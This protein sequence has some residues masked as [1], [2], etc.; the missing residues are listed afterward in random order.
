VTAVLWS[1]GSIIKEK[2]TI[3]GPAGS[4]GMASVYKA[5]HIP[6]HELRALKV[7]NAEMSADEG[8]HPTLYTGG[9]PSQKA[10][11]P[12]CRACGR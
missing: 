4:G 9:S 3:I 2:Y 12:E 7:M 1:N 10:S 8:L 6:F 5:E 11:T